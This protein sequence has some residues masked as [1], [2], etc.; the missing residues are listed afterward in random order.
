MLCESGATIAAMIFFPQLDPG[1][2]MIARTREPAHVAVDAGSSQALGQ[3][4]AQQQM[5]DAQVGIAGERIAPVFPERVDALLGMEL[6]DGVD[7]ALFERLRY[8]SRTS[9]R[10]SASSRH[11]SG[12]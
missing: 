11:R 6:A 10:K 3:W 7:P 4:W 5:V 2:R 8:A 1:R 9:G 12:A